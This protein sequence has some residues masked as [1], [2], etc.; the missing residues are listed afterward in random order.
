MHIQY[1]PHIYLYTT[2]Q[3]IHT[4]YH[5]YINLIACILSHLYLDVSP[6]DHMIS[7]WIMLMNKKTM[8]HWN[9]C[10]DDSDD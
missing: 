2:C 5:F 10:R 4:G 3:H 7:N 8:F 6:F 1:A 9:E